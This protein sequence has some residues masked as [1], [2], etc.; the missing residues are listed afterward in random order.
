MNPSTDPAARL[1][2]ER[3]STL[4]RLAALD[5]DFAALVAASVDSNADD[6]HDP[7]G[8]TLAFERSQLST[9]IDQAHTTLKAL[10]RA[11]ARLAEGSYGVCTSCGEPIA[12][13]R[14]AARPTADSCIGCARTRTVSA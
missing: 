14:L 9:L 12:P 6:E 4:A 5:L 13:A 11:D 8:T 7:E 3:R 1:E 2:A 10:D